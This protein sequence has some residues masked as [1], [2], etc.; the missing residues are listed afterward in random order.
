MFMNDKQSKLV[1]SSITQCNDLTKQ[2][3]ARR[4]L[5]TS[6]D[7][8]PSTSITGTYIYCT[9]DQS[10]FNRCNGSP[11]VK[12]QRTCHRSH[13][14]PTRY[15]N[16]SSITN[17]NN[18]S[19]FTAFPASKSTGQAIEVK[20]LKKSRDS[21]RLTPWKRCPK[22]SSLLHAREPRNFGGGPVGCQNITAKNQ[23]L[24]EERS[25][26]GI[27]HSSLL[28]KYRVGT[29]TP[30]SEQEPRHM[31]APQYRWNCQEADI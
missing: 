10:Q 14:S 30:V 19:L 27:Q 5:T 6:V 9:G 12:T 26:T 17:N 3:Q 2:M 23:S 1:R 4:S 28:F 31:G 8:Y 16:K 15:L 11:F 13:T 18:N 25:S 21:S 20:C 7:N 22:C 29:S 24:R